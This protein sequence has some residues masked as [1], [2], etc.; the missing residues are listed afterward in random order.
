MKFIALV[1]L[2]LLS[3]GCASS[4]GDA[5][6]Q[7]TVDKQASARIHTELAAVYYG[8]HQYGV[9]LDELKFALSM[10]SKYAPA[11]GV[12]GLVYMALLEDTK[13][14]EDFARSL[15]LDGND[16]GTRNNYGWF[17]CQRGRE[18]ESMAQFMEAV[19]NPLYATPE[20]AYLNAGLCSK[21]FGRIN[22]A[23]TF[24]KNALSLQPK[25]TE[26]L[27]GMAEL[28]FSKADYAGAKSYYL[29]LSRNGV[30]LSAADLLL[31]ARVERK[32]GD[33]NAEASYKLQLRKRFPESRETQLMLSGQ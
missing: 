12:R 16:S 17:L 29:R 7:S 32:L 22:E 21:K 30:E 24:L 5:Q 26:A 10:D 9:A 27:L 1:L 15:D 33:K 14:E 11:Y 18:K 28:S 31:A 4:G 25:M 23:E 3:A 6:Q 19:K 8:Q 20:K 13:A 2:A